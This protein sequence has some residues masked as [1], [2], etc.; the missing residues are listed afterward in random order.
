MNSP[1][2]NQSPTSIVARRSSDGG[3]TW[4]GLS[5]IVNGSAW[6]P[7]L[8]SNGNPV[9]LLNEVILVT[10]STDKDPTNETYGENRLVMSY[11][12]GET[13]IAI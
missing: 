9:E 7:S 6:S 12:G 8:I 5:T 2:T 1:G 10:Y 11:D 4:D 13:W 3:K